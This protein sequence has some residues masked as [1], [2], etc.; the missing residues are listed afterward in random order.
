MLALFSQPG[1]LPWLQWRGEAHEFLRSVWHFLNLE[2]NVGPHVERRGRERKKGKE[3][4]TERQLPKGKK[5][6]QQTLLS[7]YCVSRIFPGGQTG[8]HMEENM[9]DMIFLFTEDKYCRHYLSEYKN[10]QMWRLS[11]SWA[12]SRWKFGARNQAAV[13]SLSAF[14]DRLSF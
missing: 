12:Q 4:H 1:K 5:K 10:I 7:I 2:I 11:V 14:E 3:K 6:N 13:C 8:D 9:L